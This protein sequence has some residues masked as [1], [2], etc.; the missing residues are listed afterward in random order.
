MVVFERGREMMIKVFVLFYL[1]YRICCYVR[2]KQFDTLKE[3]LY[4]ILFLYFSIMAQVTI[5]KYGRLFEWPSNGVENL[6]RINMSP[7]IETIKML[8]SAWNT[9]YSYYQVIANILLFMPLGFLLPLLFEDIR[10]WKKI[11]IYGCLTSVIIEVAQIFT[12]LN[13]TDIDDVILNTLGSLLGYACYLL[14]IKLAYRLNLKVFVDK[15]MITSSSRLW[16]KSV[17]PFSLMI[18]VSVVMSVYNYFDQTVSASLSDEELLLENYDLDLSTYVLGKKVGDYRFILQ[19]HKD[20]LDVKVYEIDSFNRLSFPMSYGYDLI[21]N[22]KAYEQGFFEEAWF[23]F[24]INEEASSVRMTY[25]DESYEELLPLG[26]YLVIYPN[27]VAFDLFNQNNK[28]EFL[29][30]LGEVIESSELVY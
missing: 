25:M 13:V 4:F 27:E 2:S 1:I 26:A 16:K 14:F 24:G 23:V 10:S 28:I 15:L 30:E 22:E 21:S 5:F 12:L 9:R 18:M 7:L 6:N 8:N 20:F 19:E 29:N 11:F 3:F 17:A